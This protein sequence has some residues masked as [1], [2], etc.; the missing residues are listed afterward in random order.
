MFFCRASS[1]KSMSMRRRYSK[2]KP[3]VSSS[4]PRLLK[5]IFSKE[6]VS[7]MFGFCQPEIQLDSLAWQ[8]VISLLSVCCAVKSA[9]RNFLPPKRCSRF[10]KQVWQVERN[11]SG[12]MVHRESHNTRRHKRFT[13]D[14]RSVPWNSPF[15]RRKCSWGALTAVIHSAMFYGYMFYHVYQ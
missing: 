11:F 2:Q 6:S 10:I 1:M 4:Q 8:P 12:V 14:K 15:D 9:D 5:R 13:C 7:S 3:A